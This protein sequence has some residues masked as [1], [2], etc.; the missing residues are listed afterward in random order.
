MS[1]KRMIDP[2][3]WCS[4]DVSK[5]NIFERLLLVGLF[6]NADDFGKGRAN[7]AYIRST[8]FPYDDIG[9]EQINVSLVN[10]EK[11][12]EIIFYEV[13]NCKY[14]KFISWSKWQ[15]V[16]KPQQSKIPEPSEPF[17]EQSPNIPQTFPEPFLERS[18]TNIKE[19]NI[20]EVVVVKDNSPEKF[21]ENNFGLI[22]PF[23]ADEIRQFVENDKV[24]EQLI[25]ALMQKAVS[26]GVRKW[27]YVAKAV[28]NCLGHNI[29][30]LKQYT[31]SEEERER[32][33]HARDRP[34]VYKKPKNRKV[35]K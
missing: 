12:I 22:T 17:P 23:I 31:V 13:D 30:T 35:L 19:V 14:Y 25:V 18:G 32:N 24:E 15:K 10:I 1:R 8:V 29:T 28:N 26:A 11:Y 27:N 20:K 9:L 4:E 7:P 34:N 16:E 33:I 5:L 2:N 6:S 21:Y 3:L